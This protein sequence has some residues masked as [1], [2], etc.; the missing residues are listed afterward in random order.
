[1]KQI[2][3]RIPSTLYTLPFLFFVYVLIVTS[4]LLLAGNGLRGVFSAELFNTPR[5]VLVLVAGPIAILIFLGFFLFG[6]VSETLHSE[7]ASRF[8]L[9][10]FLSITLCVLCASVPQTVIVA[11]FTS[12]ALETWFDRPVTAALSSA[13]DISVLY[14]RERIRLVKLVSDR[15]FTALSIDKYQKRPVDWMSDIRALDPGGAACQV[16]QEVLLS[17]KRRFLPVIETGD[18]RRFVPRDRVD[19]I[20]TGLFSLTGDRDVYRYG[21]IVHYGGRSYYCAY[22][23][24]LPPDFQKKQSLILSARDQSRIVDTLKPFLPLMGVWIFLMFGLPSIL[25]T[26]I[27]AFAL[28]VRLSEPLKDLA[29]SVSR[30]AAGD[31]SLIAVPHCPDESRP[32][33]DGVN[34]LSARPT[35]RKGADKKA[36]LRL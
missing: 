35:T 33:L 22:T 20:Q 5:G 25:M 26:V 11:R 15:F 28:S 24:A 34:S 8:R 14:E 31:G 4:S 9:R 36:T 23:S 30:L 1:L 29:D 32:A 2:G 6:I 13:E 12:T 19:A 10:L 17:D 3:R 27:L 18:S 7:G 16:Y 21:Q